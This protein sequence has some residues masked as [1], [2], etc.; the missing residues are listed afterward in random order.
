ML[1][2]V[3]VQKERVLLSGVVGKKAFFGNFKD[4][5]LILYSTPKLVY[6]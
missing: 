6:Y 2:S 1:V 3:G 4:R 5:N